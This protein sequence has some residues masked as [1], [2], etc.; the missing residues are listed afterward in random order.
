MGPHQTKTF[1]TVKE[2]INKWRNCLLNVKSYL[3]IFFANCLIKDYYPKVHKT[4]TSQHKNKQ[5]INSGHRAWIDLFQGRRSI[6][7]ENV[8]CIT[9]HEGNANQNH[10]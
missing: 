9:N 3:Q 2:T 10:N 7:C 8:L 1:W 6:A 4:P 5:I